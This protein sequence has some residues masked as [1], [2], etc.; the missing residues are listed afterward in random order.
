MHHIDRYSESSYTTNNSEEYFSLIN[1]LSQSGKIVIAS[2]ANNR[3][4][5]YPAI[6]QCVIGVDSSYL[7]I[8]VHIGIIVD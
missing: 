4:K 3:T 7:S 6:M 8:I 5:S 1:R 2:L